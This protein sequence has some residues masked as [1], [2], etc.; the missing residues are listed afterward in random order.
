MLILER[1]PFPASAEYYRASVP[2][3]LGRVR[4]LGS[5]DIY[6]WYLAHSGGTSTSTSTSTS[7]GGEVARGDD[8]D[9][10]GGGTTDAA[11]VKINLVWP[12]SDQHIKKYS[13]QGVRMVTETPDVYRERVRPFM[14]ARRGGGRLNWVY[15][16][17][18]GTSEAEDVVYRTPAAAGAGAGDGG[19][20]DGFV[21][22]PDLNWDRRTPETLHLLAVVAR[23]DL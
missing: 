2:A 3:T 11:D 15:N 22:V 12:C 10:R 13:R 5:N 20:E 4:N 8:G 18:D 1:A 14:E 9:E 16:M 17:L 23:R 21:L 19:D 6:H 7:S